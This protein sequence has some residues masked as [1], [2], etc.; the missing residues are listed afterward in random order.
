MTFV[1]STDM[2]IA[3]VDALRASEQM[4]VKCASVLGVR[5]YRKTLIQILPTR[6]K[7]KRVDVRINNLLEAGIFV[8][9]N[10]H[11]PE[12][13][14]KRNCPCEMETKHSCRRKTSFCCFLRFSDKML[15]EVV[16]NTLLQNQRENLHKKA[17]QQLDTLAE[18][19][20]AHINPNII[21]RDCIRFVGD[22]PC[23]HSSDSSGKHV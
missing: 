10:T 19:Y 1:S 22:D 18:K 21:H 20:R 7:E 8:C 11:A 13:V 23:L 12:H 9:G 17:A 4:L 6:V 14:A 3:R 16:Y 5:F 2:V 15:Q